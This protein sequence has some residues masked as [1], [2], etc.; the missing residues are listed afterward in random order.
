MFHAHGKELVYKNLIWNKPGN[1]AHAVIAAL[2]LFPLHPSDRIKFIFRVRV[3]FEHHRFCALCK[4]NRPVLF[5]KSC[6]HG[7]EFVLKIFFLAVIVFVVR[8]YV[9]NVGFVHSVALCHSLDFL[10]R[11]ALYYN[12]SVL[13]LNIVVMWISEKYLCIVR[14]LNGN[15][16]FVRVIVKEETAVS[17]NGGVA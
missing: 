3:V 12:N 11:K 13:T 5:P 15:V 9:L 14:K 4:V 1:T 8:L 16:F 10:K 17:V 2:N 7:Y 6:E